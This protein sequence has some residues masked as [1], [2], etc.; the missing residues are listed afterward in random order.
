[1]SILG[2]LLEITVY[3]ALIFCFIMLFKKLFGKNISPL[4]HYLIWLLLVVRL[5]MP[6]TIDSGFNLFTIPAESVPV[7]EN[8]QIPMTD[9]VNTD[10]YTPDESISETPN[11]AAADFSRQSNG[12][13]QTSVSAEPA[14]AKPF[15]WRT[16]LLNVW[17][18][19]AALS[20]LYLAW[21]YLYLKSRIRKSAVS[22]DK[23]LA[24]I[25][26]QCVRELGIKRNIRMVLQSEISSPALLVF[27]VMLIP[28]DIMRTMDKQQIA[29][30]IK[31][32]LM[33]YKRKDHIA[34]LLLSL[35]QA[36]YWFNPFVWL[37]Y[38]QI[39]MDM[40]TACDSMV[41]KTMDGDERLKYASTIL[42]LFSR[43]KQLPV[44]LGMAV[45]NTK[46]T[47]EK[48]LKGIY[49]KQTSNRKGRLA[50]AM[51]VCVMLI[52]CF[53]TACQPTPDKPIIV[54]KNESYDEIING[55]VNETDESVS[56]P[57]MVPERITAH[58]E[59]GDLTINADT[60][61]EL[62][63]ATNFPV[64][65]VKQR[66]LSQEEVNHIVDYFA[67]G[68]KMYKQKMYQTKDEIMD[69][70]TEAKR[71]QYTDGAWDASYVDE[72]WIKELE[73]RYEDAPEAFEKEYV[74]ASLD[75]CLDYNDTQ[76]K[77]D[78]KSALNVN[79]ENDNGTEERLSIEN[80]N[81]IHNNTWVSYSDDTIYYDETFY[82]EN[83]D[84]PDIDADS[85]PN[86]QDWE[87]QV[88][89]TTMSQEQ[90]IAEGNAILDA[91]NIDGLALVDIDRAAIL[92][93]NYYPCKGGYVLSY[94]RKKGNLTG[95][96]SYYWG[97]SHAQGEELPEY[98]PP[99]EQERIEIM[100]NED[101]I[102]A[103]YWR[104]IVTE[105]EIIND[106]AKLKAFEDIKQAAF[107]QMRYKKSFMT[108]DNTKVR[109]ELESAKLY[110]GYISVKD[111]FTKALMVPMWVFVTDDYATFAD[112]EEV[113]WGYEAI[114]VNALDGS[115][116][117]LHRISSEM[118]DS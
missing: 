66:I 2:I 62:P 8:A 34:C 97:M 15:N 103:F 78:E 92:D 36:V 23:E 12:I 10:I 17:I 33:H 53:T 6:V 82:I 113:D 117:S 83:L 14:A 32:E 52:T 68:R 27:P 91:L 69:M 88:K 41:V 73:K 45:V 111:D 70:I 101:G 28:A 38:R 4:L 107:N 47:A 94:M 46:K 75:F 87:N 19:G 7:S 48:R 30:A 54:N 37:S 105:D 20:I 22:P 9:T 112:S 96:F 76:V 25:F 11:S 21:S 74:D 18:T 55:I 5:I 13:P 49:M 106:N 59:E 98:A 102:H 43:K 109:C 64:I 3:S 77:S 16:L 80:A 42:S 61:V 50:A 1:M 40:E 58:F 72:E 108:Q 95:F 51:L 99:F 65:I 71:G 63:Q 93:S 85:D 89:N 44:M 104:G 26:H 29:F 116:V 56:E 84:A 110:L 31:H 118:L 90:A 35:L 115:I 86:F 60:E 79:I 57:Y 114:A 24:D 100:L 81:E 39:R 67:Q